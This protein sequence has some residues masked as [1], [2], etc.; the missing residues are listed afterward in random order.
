MRVLL[1]LAIAFTAAQNMKV[2]YPTTKKIDQVD[3]YHGTSVPDP[4]RWLEDDNSGRP[5]PG[6]RRR[7]P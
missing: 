1:V 7:T 4:Y 6:S 3:G 5:W 2:E